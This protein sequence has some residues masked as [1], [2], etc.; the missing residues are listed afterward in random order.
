MVSDFFSLRPIRNIS[1]N[2]IPKIRS[3]NGSH[4]RSSISQ[5]NRSA[6]P[7]LTLN[8]GRS[9][10]ECQT[11]SSNFDSNGDLIKSMSM[12]FMTGGR[13]PFTCG[14]LSSKM[15]NT[16][17]KKIQIISNI[18]NLSANSDILKCEANS[19]KGGAIEIIKETLD[20]A[21]SANETLPEITNTVQ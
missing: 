12:R 19:S 10:D 17:S 3:S 16:S 11:I 6:R 15:K 7:S 14:L 18:I 5:T 13:N 21:N 2:I 8:D 9:M 4:A 20:K 1:S